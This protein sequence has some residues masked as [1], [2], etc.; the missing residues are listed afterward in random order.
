MGRP[1]GGS[2]P[3]APGGSLPAQ[4]VDV[5]R[6]RVVWA[7]GCG[8][9]SHPGA[10]TACYAQMWLDNQL[11]NPEH[12]AEPFDLRGLNPGAMES[13]EYYDGITNTPARYSR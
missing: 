3:S 5:I 1:T 9:G 8:F 12:P 10:G 4:E 7:A 6:H 11:V 13:I 2:K